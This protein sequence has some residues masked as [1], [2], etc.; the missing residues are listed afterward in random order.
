MAL[1]SFVGNFALNTSTG[2]Q[3]VTGVGFLP[4]I[5]LFLQTTRTAD[6]VQADMQ[7]GVGAGISS[8]E[9]MTWEYNSEDA[10]GTTDTSSKSS[11]TLCLMLNNPGSQTADIE[12]DLVSL[13]ADGF[14]VNITTAPTSAYR[15]GYFA[16][17]G[18]DLTN[19]DIGNFAA[20]NST[21][22]QS[23]TGV[24]FQPDG[25]IFLNNQR[26][27]F[28]GGGDVRQCMGFATSSSERGCI[29]AFSENGIV[30]SN[31]TRHQR[32]N[33][34]IIVLGTTGA[35]IGLADFVSFDA[36]G[37]TVN[38]SN[39][40]DALIG[41]IAF[42]GGQYFVGSLT[43]QT[44]TGNF[45]ET[46]VGFQGEAGIFASFC[47][48]AD[49]GLVSHLDMSIGI[50]TGSAN[51]FV[52]GGWDLGGQATS[53]VDGSQNDGLVYEHYD[54]SQIVE[55]AADFVS[56]GSDGFTL[57]MTNSEPATGKEVIYMIFGDAAGA[58]A[59]VPIIQHH[60]RMQGVFQ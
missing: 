18:T 48:V 7:M 53:S 13:D 47:N 56:W 57:N 38:W 26:T 49:A 28:S 40:N 4:K 45:A 52:I 29:G 43:T 3:A 54:Y 15:I 24:G 5:V 17:G 31:T 1:D 19:V 14:T 25:I 27:S 59:T 10:Q 34:C 42:K 55:A 20:S 32:T 16:L 6:G 2:N 23:V 51:R 9:R 35:E 30:T 11:G 21:G 8:T 46:G 39:A 50:V 33:A 37:F 22:N 12:A 58:A 44:S 36:D 41:Y 60:R